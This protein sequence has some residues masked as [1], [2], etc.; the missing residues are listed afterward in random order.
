MVDVHNLLNHSFLN[1]LNH[2]NLAIIN[3]V[4]RDTLI[5]KSLSM[6]YTISLIWMSGNEMIVSKY[7]KCFYG[8]LYLLPN[9]RFGKIISIYILIIDIKVLISPN[10]PSYY[11]HLRISI[12]LID[13]K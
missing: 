10:P 7:V 12:N 8:P 4:T 13:E 3:S 5:F 6:V 9:L 11:N 2:F 1:H